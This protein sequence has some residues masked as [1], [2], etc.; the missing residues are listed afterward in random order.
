M[1]KGHHEMHILW[2]YWKAWI[3]DK[4]KAYMV[5]ANIGMKKKSAHSLLHMR[6]EEGERILGAGREGQAGT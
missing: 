1:K 3:K 6:E 5:G 4:G 2:L